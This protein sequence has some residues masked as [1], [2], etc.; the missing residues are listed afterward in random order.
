MLGLVAGRA[1]VCTAPALSDIDCR[2]RSRRASRRSR[3]PGR[4][5]Q[6]P[7][8]FS[9]P[10]HAH[11]EASH[12]RDDFLPR[13]IVREV[14]APRPDRRPRR[15]APRPVCRRPI[16]CIATSRCEC[17][18]PCTSRSQDLFAPASAPGDPTSRPDSSGAASASGREDPGAAGHLP[19]PRAWDRCPG[20]RRS[21]TSSA[22]SRRC[23][24]RRRSA[25]R[26]R[27]AR[28]RSASSTGPARPGDIRGR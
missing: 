10:L 11:E 6:T 14:V 26:A 3:Q 12:L 16:P 13:R 19:D 1:V 25:A 7:R 15:T 5:S 20:T 21:S 8:R 23:R 17:C 27:S 24:D 18:S 28:T 9:L 2:D 22:P 4:L